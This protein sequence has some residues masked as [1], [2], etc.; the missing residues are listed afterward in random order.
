MTINR[1]DTLINLSRAFA[2]LSAITVLAVTPAFAQA[3]YGTG[4]AMAPHTASPNSYG[5]GSVR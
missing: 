2:V 5:T 4:R 1:G 3:S